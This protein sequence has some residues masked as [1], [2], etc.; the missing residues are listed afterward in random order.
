VGN[1][2]ISVEIVSDAS[3]LESSNSYQ[4]VVAADS[5][6]AAYV[7]YGSPRSPTRPYLKPAVTRAKRGFGKELRARLS[8]WN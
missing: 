5:D 8:T 2:K 4:I 1:R 6:H 3:K 7:E